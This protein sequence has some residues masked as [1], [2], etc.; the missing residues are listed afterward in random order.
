MGWF[1]NTDKPISFRMSYTYE[2]EYEY[3]YVSVYVYVYV[4]AYIYVYVYAYIYIYI[5]SHVVHIL[6]IYLVMYM[7]IYIYTHLFIYSFIYIY[8]YVNVCKYVCMYTYMYILSYLP[9]S[10]WYPR[11][12]HPNPRNSISISKARRQRSGRQAT[13][14][15][16]IAAGAFDV[17]G[18]HGRTHNVRHARKVVGP[19][20]KEPIHSVHLGRDTM[21]IAS[22]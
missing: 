10:A 15:R 9:I 1:N 11:C 12:L 13:A 16:T 20:E 22:P 19:A 21:D 14:Q 6:F 7:H 18:P 2:Y 4:Y 3:E 8:I 17:V 5:Y